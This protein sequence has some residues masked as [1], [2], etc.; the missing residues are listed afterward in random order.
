MII[1][2]TGYKRSG[3]DTVGSII[4]NEFNFKRYA[5]ADKP[6]L[7]M[8]DL[9]DIP[10]SVWETDEKDTIIPKYGKSPREMIIDL[11]THG[12]RRAYEDVWS[13]YLMRKININYDSVITDVRFPNEAEAILEEGGYIIRVE[14]RGCVLGNDIVTTGLYDYTYDYNIK[15]IQNN[16]TLEEL[17]TKV[18]TLLA[19]MC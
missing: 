14:R 5:F 16:G 9:F 2:L 18:K 7:L 15:I 3:K 10:M 6:K 12:A 1:G 8:L 17:S 19:T 4:E 11:G 13:D